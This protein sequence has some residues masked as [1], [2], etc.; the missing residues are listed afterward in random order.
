MF[1]VS[2][3]ND[4]IGDLDGDDLATNGEAAGLSGVANEDEEGDEEIHTVSSGDLD[5]GDDWAGFD[6]WENRRTAVETGSAVPAT[7]M[8]K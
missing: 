1:C 8:I 4:G 5:D 3:E 7:M 2:G 6:E